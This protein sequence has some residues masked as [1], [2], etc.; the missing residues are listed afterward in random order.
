MRVVIRMPNWLGDIVMALPA[1][2]AIRAHFA[3]AT[4]TGAAPASLAPLVGL[5]PGIDETIALG[6]GR[7]LAAIGAVRADARALAEGRFDVAIL[8]PN[9]FR[10]AW[11][12]RR[13]GVPE[14]WGYR[15][16]LRGFLLTRAVRRPRHAK[17]RVRHQSE[18]YLDLVRGLGIDAVAV[19]A[20]IAVPPEIQARARDLLTRAGCAPDAVL[21]GASPGAAYGH[22]K[23]WPPDRF[24]E[25]IS[26][27]CHERGATCVLAGSRGDRDAGDAIE[28]WLA[29]AHGGRGGPSRTPATGHVLNLVG[30]TDL[31]TLAGLM[32]LCR[33][34]VS[35][36]SG[37]MHLAAAVGVAVTAIFGPTDERATAPLGA[38]QVLTHPVWCRPCLLR[39]CPID[40]RCMTGIPPARVFDAVA[41]HLDGRAAG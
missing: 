9:S 27:L 26:R 38:H 18:Y 29:S 20:R 22:A 24:G 34:W 37:A 15:T 4:L 6:G 14:R 11:A 16:D 8:L 25:L 28:S 13:A 31:P 12:V 10:S 19:A 1:V 39:E 33:A 21:V 41:R 7:G 30:R 3:S 23:C 17:R 2:A 36:D 32:S 35:N 5:V 40:H